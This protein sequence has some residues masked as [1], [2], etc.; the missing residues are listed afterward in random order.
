[1]ALWTL[2]VWL[3]VGALAGFLTRKIMGGTSPFGII[4]DIILGLA[5]GVVGGYILALTGLSNTLGSLVISIIA[6]IVG[7]VVL[8]WS[9]RFLKKK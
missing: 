8:V 6:A 7:A 9:T 1:M 4:G 2:F 3:G 5:G